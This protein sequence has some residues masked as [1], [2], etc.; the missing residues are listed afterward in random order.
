LRRTL[1]RSVIQLSKPAVAVL[2]SNFRQR[3]TAYR[4]SG[5]GSSGVDLYS[6]VNKLFVSLIVVL[7]P[8]CW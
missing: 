8:L 3:P 6:N 4:S 2:S 7:Q 1:V 5:N